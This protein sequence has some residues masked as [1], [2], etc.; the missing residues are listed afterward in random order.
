[1]MLYTN[2]DG[3][4]TLIALKISRFLATH[5]RTFRHAAEKIKR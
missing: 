3:R 2:I 4:A 1:M 5:G